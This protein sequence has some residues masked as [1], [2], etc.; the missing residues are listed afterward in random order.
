MCCQ[1][2]AVVQS[3]YSDTLNIHYIWKKKIESKVTTITFFYFMEKIL[4]E[5]NNKLG[6]FTLNSTYGS[7]LYHCEDHYNEN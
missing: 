6:F 5:I 3:L 4:K 1:N 2:Y 7:H